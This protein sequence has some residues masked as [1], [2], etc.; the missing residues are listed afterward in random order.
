MSSQ[1]QQVQ[2]QLGFFKLGTDSVSPISLVKEE[3]SS[4]AITKVEEKVSATKPSNTDEADFERF[5]S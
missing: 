3:K 5:G 1:V 4:P 2:T